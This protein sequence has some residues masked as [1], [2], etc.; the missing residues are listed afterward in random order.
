MQSSRWASVRQVHNLDL[1]KFMSE[2]ADSHR[3]VKPNRVA[4]FK[5]EINVAQGSS[6]TKSVNLK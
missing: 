2:K 3:Y 1:I 5:F 4:H 6:L